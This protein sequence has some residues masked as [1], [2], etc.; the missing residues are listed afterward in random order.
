[1]QENRVSQELPRALSI[2]IEP[3]E[4]SSKPVSIP[5]ESLQT[6]SIKE[7]SIANQ[8]LSRTQKG[9]IEPE[10]K[11][12]IDQAAIN[13]VVSDMI[14]EELKDP[15]RLAAFNSTFA[16]GEATTRRPKIVENE[17]G[18]VSVTSSFIGKTVCYS[19]KPDA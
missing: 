11:T 12:V 15:A 17:D 14:K 1:M 7:T 13:A 18:T 9:P 3:R 2:S 4:T 5:L 6:P 10:L 8:R 19:F 16:F